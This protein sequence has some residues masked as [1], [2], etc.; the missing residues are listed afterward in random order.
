M[1]NSL[2]EIQDL[3]YCTVH[4]ADYL[5]QILDPLLYMPPVAMVILTA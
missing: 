3:P 1:R 2:S 4:P 5:H